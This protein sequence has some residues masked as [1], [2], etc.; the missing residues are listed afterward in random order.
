MQ[1]GVVMLPRLGTLDTS[2]SVLLNA[3]GLTHKTV[4][5]IRNCGGKILQCYTW[6]ALNC[7]EMISFIYIYSDVKYK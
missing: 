4:T 1:A 2:F 5:P 3:S 6:L 7:C